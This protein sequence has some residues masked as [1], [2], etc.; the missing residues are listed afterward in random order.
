[1]CFLVESLHIEQCKSAQKHYDISYFGFP[2]KFFHWLPNHRILSLRA[3]F[4][5]IN[6]KYIGEM[7][8]F[9]IYRFCFCL[10]IILKLLKISNIRPKKFSICPTEQVTRPFYPKHN[11]IVV[12]Q[13]QMSGYRFDLIIL[14]PLC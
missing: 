1:M 4:Y 10:Y 13:L 12:A 5:I 9:Q 7:F 3:L 14:A 6:G 2:V 8:E 11:N